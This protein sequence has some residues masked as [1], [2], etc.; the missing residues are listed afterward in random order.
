MLFCYIHFFTEMC[1]TNSFLQSLQINSSIRLMQAVEDQKPPTD[2]NRHSFLD[3]FF[4]AY[5]QKSDFF[6]L[7]K[8]SLC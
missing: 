8:A 1:L 3:F 6:S 5:I 7:A 4:A 2:L